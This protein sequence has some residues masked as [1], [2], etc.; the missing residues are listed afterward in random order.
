MRRQQTLH[1]SV[2]HFVF[3]FF[4]LPL[5]ELAS[6]GCFLGEKRRKE[7]DFSL[8]PLPREQQRRL[9]KPRPPR[10]TRRRVHSLFI[11]VTREAGVRPLFS[12]LPSTHCT[13]SAT[14]KSFAGFA[15]F[16]LVSSLFPPFPIF[17]ALKSR[18]WEEKK[19]PCVSLTSPSSEACAAGVAAM[20]TAA[21]AAAFSPAT[22]GEENREMKRNATY[23]HGG[24]GS[25]GD[26]KKTPSVLHKHNVSLPV[27][28]PPLLGSRASLTLGHLGASGRAH[29]VDG[30][31]LFLM[32]LSAADGGAGTEHEWGGDHGSH[33]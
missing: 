20:V 17:C 24:R 28:F 16:Q 11:L 10:P 14:S 26:Q 4:F 6:G 33:C 21:T 13:K 30:G 18:G 23:L 12:S 25:S 29:N 31:G 15:S 2:I 22:R 27:T 5:G 1:N 9:W 8:P 19:N 7:A 3:S 32:Y